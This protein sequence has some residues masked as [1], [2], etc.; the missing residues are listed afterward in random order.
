MI[1]TKTKKCLSG[2]YIL[3]N[4]ETGKIYIGS[5]V[6]IIFRIVQHFT[7]LENNRHVNKELQKDYNNGY[8]IKP[9]FHKIYPVKNKYFLLTE[10][11][12]TISEFKKKNYSLYNKAKLLE[13]HFVTDNV[14]KT[15]IADAYCKEKYG[16]TFS[17]FTSNFVPA[18]YSMYYEI[19][20]KPD[21]TEEIK[22]YFSDAIS[23]QRKEYFYRTHPKIKRKMIQV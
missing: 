21:K 19:L 15:A 2:V 7:D 18:E 8:T 16:V 10:E 4:E 11:G 23:Y 13:N 17:Q 22:D 20:Q 9:Y 5:S 12:K 14:L 3:H 6:D 1:E